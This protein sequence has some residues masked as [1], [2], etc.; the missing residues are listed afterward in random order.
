[1]TALAIY[2]RNP[3]LYSFLLSVFFISFFLFY[4]PSLDIEED[5][6]PTEKLT[7]V[8]IDTIEAPKRIVKKTISTEEGE[9]SETETTERA[10]GTSDLSNA[11]DLSF[12]PNIAPPKPIGRLKKIYPKSAREMS[13]EATL[14]VEIFIA[15]SG[16][17]INVHIRG[18]RL[19]KDLPPDV[20]GKIVA[21]FTRAAR[22]TL[23]GARF[24]PPVV[25]GK[26]VPVKMEMPLRFVMN[27][28]G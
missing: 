25:Q 4:S 22:K 10:K 19:N 26:K 9:V 7:I 15:P 5:I 17:V 24:T 28:E 3:Y 1:M 11:V 13:I 14:Y 8:D 20:Y 2:D 12:Y 23:I 16:K 6:S 18:A 27:N 21:D